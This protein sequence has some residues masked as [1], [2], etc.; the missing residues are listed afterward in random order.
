MFAFDRPS[1]LDIMGLSLRS[2][3][4]P[5]SHAHAATTGTGTTIIPS[6]KGLATPVPAPTVALLEVWNNLPY[7]HLYIIVTYIPCDFVRVSKEFRELAY[8]HLDKDQRVRPN[9]LRNTPLRAMWSNDIRAVE[10]LCRL[11]WGTVGYYLTVTLEQA[12][13]NGKLEFFKILHGALERVSRP[14]GGV[15]CMLL[16]RLYR[17]AFRACRVEILEFMHTATRLGPIIPLTFDDIKAVIRRKDAAVLSYILTR[18]M[19]L[20]FCDSLHEWIATNTVRDIFGASLASKYRPG[21]SLVYQH[22]HK[23]HP[24]AAAELIATFDTLV[25]IEQVHAHMDG[26]FEWASALANVKVTAVI[27]DK[28]APFLYSPN[29]VT[30]DLPVD[31][32]TLAPQP[33]LPGVQERAVSQPP[34]DSL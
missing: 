26:D 28:V 11:D 9:V 32:V 8:V 13:E 23:R 15:D 34:P 20:L 27:M 4:R 33:K 18:C 7:D 12:A 17:L 31:T 19:R 24:V 30:F 25:G 6:G 29:P 1:I 22:L 21:L 2:S 16:G 10:A 3:H 5:P 14:Q